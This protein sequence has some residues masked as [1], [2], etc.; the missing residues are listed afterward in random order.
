MKAIRL[1]SE[2]LTFHIEI[3][4]V[5][6]IPK[7]KS[8]QKSKDGK[9][10]QRHG[11]GAIALFLANRALSSDMVPMEFASSGARASYLALEDIRKMNE[12]RG[13]G[14]VSGGNDFRGW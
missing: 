12:D 14:S 13:Y 9:R 11:D 2:V 4:G 7:E 10:I 6:K 1:K 3:N 8:Q 5:P